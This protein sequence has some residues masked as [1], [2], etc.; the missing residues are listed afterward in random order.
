M[1]AI[2]EVILHIALPWME[3][4]LI[5][6]I[7]IPKVRIRV[8]RTDPRWLGIDLR[9]TKKIDVRKLR[10]GGGE[11]GTRGRGDEGRRGGGEEGRRGG[12]E[13]WM[14]GQQFMSREQNTLFFPF[15][16]LHGGFSMHNV[17][18]D[19]LGRD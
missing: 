3:I 12:G 6:R 7:L 15:F 11:E 13:E 8:C 1:R 2:T 14:I 4:F 16:Y 17:F 5:I 18:I 19:R 9:Q 10:R